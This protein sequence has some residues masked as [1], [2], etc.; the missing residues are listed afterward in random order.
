MAISISPDFYCDNS[1]RPYH[2]LIRIF[3]QIKSVM[4]FSLIR[5]ADTDL[6]T[7]IAT[8]LAALGRNL[9]LLGRNL[10]SLEKTGEQLR[11]IY[12]VK[13][14]LFEFNETSTEEIIKIC[15]VI[16]DHFQIDLFVNYSEIDFHGKFTDR[17]VNKLIADLTT[18]YISGPI[19][20]HQL[21]PNLMLH[22]NAF[23]L[24]LYSSY[25]SK[26]SQWTTILKAQNLNFTNYLNDDMED[27]GVFVKA[28]VVE[29]NDQTCCSENINEYS[30]IAR[31]LLE[32]LFQSQI[33]AATF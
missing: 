32:S 26:P 19:F 2:Y 9:I 24:N 17:P 28:C 30:K 18:N 31:E 14:F 15:E 11:N 1:E 33:L 8:E 6:G 29:I 16:N 27:T 3:I 13:V 22:A 7:A 21:L 23:I 20:T 4:N 5:N 25:T 10:D 12:K